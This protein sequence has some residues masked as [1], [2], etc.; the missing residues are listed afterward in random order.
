MI[1]NAAARLIR[2]AIQDI[3]EALTGEEKE[4]R[5]LEVIAQFFTREKNRLSYENCFVCDVDGA[6]TGLILGISVATQ[7]ELDEP[8]VKRLRIVK[9]DPSLTIDKEADI[10]D[11]LYR[12]FMC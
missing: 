1:Q 5:I 6:I 4:E 9:N 10:E 8:L 7:P 11:S 3:A 12:Y 2:V